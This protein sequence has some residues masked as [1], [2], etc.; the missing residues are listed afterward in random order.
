MYVNILYNRH[1]FILQYSSI[2]KTFLSVKNHNIRNV[3]SNH[4]LTRC[5]IRKRECI[6]HYL[7]NSLVSGFVTTRLWNVCK[8]K[9]KTPYNYYVTN[10]N[11]LIVVTDLGRIWNIPFWK[12]KKW[13]S[14]FCLTP[15]LFQLYH[16]E[17]KLISNEMMMIMMM[18]ALY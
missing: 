10:H 16:G 8:C 1:G 4:L 12:I 6:L 2:L 5:G 7:I 11:F 17:N 15:T 3:L 13:V 18:P 14:D 9:L